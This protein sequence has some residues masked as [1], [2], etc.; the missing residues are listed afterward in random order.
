MAERRRSGRGRRSAPE[1]AAAVPAAKSD[2]WAMGFVK[3]ASAVVGLVSAVVGLV[4]LFFPQL[5]PGHTSGPS[6]VAVDLGPVQL[7]ASTTHGSFLERTD[8]SEQGFTKSQ[9]AER[10]AMATFKISITG[11][12]QK[13]LTV[14]RQLFNAHG[15]KVGQEQAWSIRPQKDEHGDHPFADW[16]ALPRGRGRYVLVFKILAPDEPTP[17]ACVQSKPFGGLGG[18]AS[19]GNPTICPPSS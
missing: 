1:A 15:D 7:D 13:P 17:V 11:Y 12:R 5:T 6:K 14:R 9:R 19:G 4:V 16:I 3:K 2:G 10:G 8:R 18:L